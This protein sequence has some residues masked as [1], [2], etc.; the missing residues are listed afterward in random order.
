MNICQEAN[1]NQ[2]C[3]RENFR[4]SLLSTIMMKRIRLEK[5]TSLVDFQLSCNLAQ[6]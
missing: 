2:S 1:K 3:R 4:D 5:T 6:S